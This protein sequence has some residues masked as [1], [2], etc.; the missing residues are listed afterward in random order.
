M[1]RVLYYHPLSS[2]CQKVLIA[3]YEVGTPFTP[4]LVDLTEGDPPFAAAWPIGK[5]PVLRDGERWIAESS[6]IIEY[7]G[8]RAGGATELLP[9]DVD[10]ALAVRMSDRFLDLYVHLP[11]QVIIGDA[12][13]PDDAHDPFG[14]ARAR[15]TLRSSFAMLDNE[16]RG[17]QWAVGDEFSLADCAAAP[18]LFYLNELTP[19]AT[20]YPVVAAYLDRLKARPSYARVLREAAPYLHMFPKE[21]VR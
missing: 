18:P 10:R 13:R 2:F 11:L 17:H 4:Q 21:R 15:E 8:Q 19:L 14:V 16:L 7:L 9:R 5:F 12:L 6:I 3:L 20:D 1:S